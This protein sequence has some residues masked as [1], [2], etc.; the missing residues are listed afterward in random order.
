MIRDGLLDG[1]PL[2]AVLNA[3][4][5]M[6]HDFPIHS[7]IVIRNLCEN[8]KRRWYTISLQLKNNNNNPWSDVL[9]CLNSMFDRGTPT[10]LST[11][12]ESMVN[13]MRARC[14]EMRTHTHKGIDECAGNHCA[15]DH[16]SS[17][18]TETCVFTR[19]C[20]WLA[21]QRLHSC[22]MT[23]LALRLVALTSI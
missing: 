14:S 23:T 15:L 8:I 22:I 12:S 5:E 11:V 2:S 10:N 9:W 21:S 13:K 16:F 3:A 4:A 20:K 18:N 1:S 6:K 17:A 19:V 7:R